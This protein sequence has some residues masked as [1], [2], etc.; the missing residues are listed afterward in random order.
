MT[1][2]IFDA[3]HEYDGFYDDHNNSFDNAR[4]VL[5]DESSLVREELDKEKERK[6]AFAAWLQK[7]NEPKKR[8]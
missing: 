3:Q 4:R 5:E 8:R 6:R 2:D 1:D 7:Q